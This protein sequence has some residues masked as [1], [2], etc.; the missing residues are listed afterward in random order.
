MAEI[1]ILVDFQAYPADPTTPVD[2]FAGETVAIGEIPSPDG[3]AVTADY[4]DMLVAKGLAART[5]EE[6]S[7]KR[8]GRG[9]AVTEASTDTPSASE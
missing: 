1:Q 5:P 9:A 7:G 3:S 2:F 4:A 6:P 8:A